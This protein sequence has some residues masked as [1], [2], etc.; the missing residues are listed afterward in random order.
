MA[1]ELPRTAA[2]CAL[3]G[4]VA[5]RIASKAGVEGGNGES[6]PRLYRMNEAEQTDAGPVLRE[7]EP[8]VA[9]K[10]TADF[11]RAPPY[12]RCK[13]VSCALWVRQ[14]GVKG[15]PGQGVKAWRQS[16]KGVRFAPEITHALLHRSGSGTGCD[17]S[18]QLLE[19]GNIR[20]RKARAERPRERTTRWL[21]TKD[22]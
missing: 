19:S 22:A 8:K 6:R 18:A 13:V 10:M 11:A 20:P 12:L 3:K 1:E 15:A 14:N 9:M 17:R 21:R 4:P 7:G 16:P 2:E 5:L